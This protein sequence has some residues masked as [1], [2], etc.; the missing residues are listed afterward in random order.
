VSSAPPVYVV[1]VNWNGWADTL[2]CLESVFRLEYPDYRV[3]VC[4]NAS[5]DGSLERIEAW[6][7]GQLEAPVAS[8]S[9][10]RR[11]SAPPVP[12]PIPCVTHDRS[13]VD[14]PAGAGPSA[15]LEL[16]AAGSNLGFAGG[17]N[18]ALRLAMARD[19]FEYAW[20]LNNDT[21]VEPPALGQLVSRMRARPAAGMCGSTLRFY[22]PPHEVQA[23]GGATY[24]AR[25]A[26]PHNVTR[27]GPGDDAERLESRLTYVMGASML[28][29]KPFLREIGPMGEDYFLFFEELDWATRAKGRYTLAYAPE[30][31]V[32]H[33]GGSST[34]LSATSY[35]RTSDF[36]MNRSQL[37]Y[38]RRYTPWWI[39]LIFLRHLLVLVNSVVRWRPA[40][41]AIL[42]KIYLDLLRGRYAGPERRPAWPPAPAEGPPTLR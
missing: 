38:A 23:H 20:L 9:P 8:D 24:N 36:Y 14:R 11:L 15:R 18:L 19:D 13:V 31:L 34:G 1:I 29:S 2:E 35:N 6:A 42:G 5:G 16:V 37:V 30:S 4:D 27:L 25:L 17:N 40:R 39:P 32:Y 41:I 22:E 12:K 28:V 21:V 10:L 3:V 33:K 7:A 26:M